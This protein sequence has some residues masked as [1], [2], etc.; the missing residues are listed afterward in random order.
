[1]RA[2]RATSRRATQRSPNATPRARDSLGIAAIVTAHGLH[3]GVP[4]MN[5]TM[6]KVIG[7]G[8]LGAA[9]FAAGE[10]HADDRTVPM[11]MTM[12]GAEAAREFTVYTPSK[13][14][15]SFGTT[16][17]SPQPA[18]FGQGYF[19][20]EIWRYDGRVGWTR[21][22]VSASCYAGGRCDVSVVGAP[23]GRYRVF[24]ARNTYGVEPSISLSGNVVLSS[25][26]QAPPTPPTSSACGGRGQP[27][28]PPPPPATPSQQKR[29]GTR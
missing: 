8:V 5:T 27:A 18:A 14:T 21:A 12:V 11:A 23:A 9:L 25:V 17:N 6:R 24:A 19:N 10:S 13:I 3:E 1:V 7:L 20:L 16:W 29:P 2:D 28:C 4:M 22:S 26:V 15:A